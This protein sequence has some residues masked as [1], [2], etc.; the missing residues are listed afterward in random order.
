MQ[1]RYKP[2]LVDRNNNVL[3]MTLYIVLNSVRA[4]MFSAAQK[5][6]WRNLRVTADIVPTED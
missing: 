4:G 1:E 6:A 5:G 3:K 2:I